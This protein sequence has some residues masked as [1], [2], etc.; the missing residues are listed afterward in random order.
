[1]SN[2]VLKYTRNDRVR[3]ISHLDFVRMF[4]RAVRRADLNM[5]F[6]QGFNPHPVMTVAMPLSVGVTA[7]GEYMKIGF[8]DEFGYTEES[9]QK[10]LN[11]SLPDGFS[12]TAVR[13]VEGKELDFAKLDRARYRVEAELKTD[14]VPDVAGF[15]KNPEL[16]VMKKTKSGEKEADIRPYIYDLQIEAQNGKELVLSMCVAAGNNYNLKPETVLAAMEKYLPDF[17]VESMLV[18]RAAILAGD[19]IL[20]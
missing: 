5:V 3:Y 8:M 12:I 4:H 11:E 14:I 16:I 7:D 9:I 15:L 13:R 10:R 2:Y 19:K 17:G 20:L 1:M 6:S 18:H